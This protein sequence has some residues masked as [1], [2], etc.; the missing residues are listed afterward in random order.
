[1]AN[2]TEYY[3]VANKRD[4]GYQA[5]LWFI[6]EIKF[7]IVAILKESSMLD[8]FS[9]AVVAADSKTACIGGDE[10]S[11]LKG[12]IAEGNKRLDAVNAVA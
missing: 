5:N 10:I 1:M 6:A 8:A 7:K 2:V 3:F 4:L 12:F 11:A 9:R